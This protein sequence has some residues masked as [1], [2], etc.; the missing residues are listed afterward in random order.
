MITPALVDLGVAFYDSLRE[1]GATDYSARHQAVC[2]MRRKDADC[3]DAMP[4]YEA[5][6]NALGSR[7]AAKLAAAARTMIQA[8][9]E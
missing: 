9:H 2:Y 8:P 6:A 1:H 4:Y 7:A 3:G 5:L